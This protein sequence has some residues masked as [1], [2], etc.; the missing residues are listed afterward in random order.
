MKYY[1]FKN[2]SYSKSDTAFVENF[3]KDKTLYLKPENMLNSS[4]LSGQGVSLA[5]FKAGYIVN[6]KF[7]KFTE[8]CIDIDNDRGLDSTKLSE[9]FVKDLLTSNEVDYRVQKTKKG[10]HIWYL[11]PN[12][13]LPPNKTKVDTFINYR[14]R[15]LKIELKLANSWVFGGPE[16]DFYYLP[17]KVGLDI[18]LKYNETGSEA[19]TYELMRDVKSQIRLKSDKKRAYSNKG[20]YDKVKYAV[21]NPSPE[22][23]F[24][25]VNTYFSK[26]LYEYSGGKYGK[27]NEYSQNDDI[28]EPVDAKGFRNNFTNLIKDSLCNLVELDDPEDIYAFLKLVNENLYIEPEDS[29]SFEASFNFERIS[30]LNR[31]ISGYGD[32]LEQDA[33]TLKMQSE[34]EQ[35]VYQTAKGSMSLNSVDLWICRDFDSQVPF[36][37]SRWVDG[38]LELTP[39]K[40]N[41]DILKSYIFGYDELRLKYTHLKTL[42]NGEVR[43]VVDPPSMFNVISVQHERGK[44][45]D[46]PLV[47]MSDTADLLYDNSSVH[48]N[49]Y[50]H[51]APDEYKWTDEQ[52]DN[53]IMAKF[54]RER[55]FDSEEKFAFFMSRLKACLHGKILDRGFC[56]I[57]SQGIGKDTF[58]NFLAN[59]MFC[60]RGRTDYRKECIY[61]NT[62]SGFMSDKW[63]TKYESS[64]IYL[65]EAGESTIFNERV[66]NSFNTIIGN[67]TA[68]IENKNERAKTIELPTVLFA[69]ATNSSVVDLDYAQNTRIVFIDC[70]ATDTL[71]NNKELIQKYFNGMTELEIAEAEGSQFMHYIYNTD[72]FD[73]IANELPLDFGLETE[74]ISRKDDCDFDVND[75]DSVI[76]D[77]EPIIKE[78]ASLWRKDKYNELNSYMTAV[79]SREDFASLKYDKFKRCIVELYWSIFVRRFKDETN[80]FLLENL[81]EGL[82][83]PEFNDTATTDCTR[84]IVALADSV[85]WSRLENGDI[86]KN[87][88]RKMSKALIENEIVTAFNGKLRRNRKIT[89]KGW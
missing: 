84:H 15:K 13:C 38:E 45:V 58:I 18:P 59:S 23:V 33:K 78:V 29:Y 60:K 69:V 82:K 47:K 66:L 71:R 68:G 42:K 81:R 70:P 53:S 8:V 46:T 12:Y 22:I 61:K 25:I 65:S 7:E 77:I 75:K 27:S 5:D 36:Y 19:M 79:M 26:K 72:R 87:L 34:L 10:V 43:L 11:A 16:L 63:G 6:E 20:L 62:I 52:F 30:K 4:D 35:I 49:R 28:F 14:D 80:L 24:S 50:I 54:A 41:P 48:Y 55:L 57:G 2:W 73:K 31:C 9:H 21:I 32:I 89:M 40:N 83:I 67:T 17:M 86:N 44:K 76:S 3:R 37:I 85:Y 88:T 51:R 64:V 39:I 56:F 1:N 74:S